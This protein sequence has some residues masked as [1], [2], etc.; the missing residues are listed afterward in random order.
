M[1]S[2]QFSPARV[3]SL[4]VLPLKHEFFGFFFTFQGWIFCTFYPLRVNSLQFSPFK[5]EFVAFLMCQDEFLAIFTLE[6]E[7]FA[8]FTL[9]GWNLCK[10]YLS[11]IFWGWKGQKKYSCNGE[12]FE[13][14][15][16]F[17]LWGRIFCIFSSLK[18]EFFLI[19]TL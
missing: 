12:F 10:F 13:I 9:Q 2:W 5:G 8:I 18:G 16:F 17:T 6:G 11:E 14:L 1:N 7:F 4:Q 15:I 19:F 3:N